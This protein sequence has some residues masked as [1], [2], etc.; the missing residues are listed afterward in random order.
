MHLDHW[1][2]SYF[3][4]YLVHQGSVDGVLLLQI[5]VIS[6]DL[7]VSQHIVSEAFSSLL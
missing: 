5:S 3:V 7:Q 6:R 4:C 1:D 2:M